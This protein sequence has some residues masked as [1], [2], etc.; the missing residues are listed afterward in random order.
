VQEVQTTQAPRPEGTFSS[1]SP[2]GTR[3]TP[4]ALWLRS[5]SRPFLLLVLAATVA[6]FVGYRL[7][8]D[9]RAL[10][11]QDLR[12]SLTPALAAF[13]FL[14][15]G[16]LLTGL[17]WIALLHKSARGQHWRDASQ[18]MRVF[19]FAWIGRYVP[20]KLP[21]FLGKVY[22]ARSLNYSL[23]SLVVATVIESTLQLLAATAFGAIMIFLAL[24]MTADKV[25]AWLALLTLPSLALLHPR[26]LAPVANRILRLLKKNEL[27]MTSFPDFRTTLLAAVLYLL[28]FASNGFG[29]HLIVLSTVDISW[30]RIP[31]SMGA[32]AL[33]GVVGIV[34]VF[35]PAGLGARE[36]SIAGTLA[37]VLGVHSAALVALFS[38]VWLTAVDV[39][40][41]GCAL[42]VDYV[43]GDRLLPKVIA[44]RR[45]HDTAS[46]SPTPKLEKPGARPVVPTEAGSLE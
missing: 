23:S 29:F 33:S 39:M 32:F 15:A 11:A 8:H 1:A 27:P 5:W 36:G 14:T 24:G 16:V 20:G 42:L 10:G 43:S 22:L 46:N 34:V 7:V 38:R 21:F 3:R 4:A 28:A 45:H 35:A 2:N 26:L 41:A 30:S 40:L 13:P 44:D 37:P 19:L 31:L 17:A 9:T 6:G 18:L 12:F 25:Y